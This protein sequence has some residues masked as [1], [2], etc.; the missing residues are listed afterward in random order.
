MPLIE[1]L[2]SNGDRAEAESCEG[3]MLAART[4][5]GDASEASAYGGMGLTAAFYVDGRLV[6]EGVRRE[7]TVR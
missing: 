2:L 6:R 1:V 5:M 4:M 3:A 7:E